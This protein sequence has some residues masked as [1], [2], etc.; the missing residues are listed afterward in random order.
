MR[1]APSVV[2]CSHSFDPDALTSKKRDA[3]KRKCVEVH[4]RFKALVERV[5]CQEAKLL[6]LQREHRT[7]LEQ[8][9]AQLSE[10]ESDKTALMQQQLGVVRSTT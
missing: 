1:V 9:L 4:E 7:E 2:S 5:N 3:Y 6:Q 10:A 8:V